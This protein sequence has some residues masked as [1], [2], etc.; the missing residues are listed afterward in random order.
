MSQS[1][2]PVVFPNKN[3]L[4][5]FGML[6]VPSPAPESQKPAILLLSPGI[7]SRIG[8]HRLY[9]KMAAR[10]IEMGFTVLRF[11]FYGLG[12]S[13]GELTESVM[14]NFY[15]SIEKGRYVE[16]TLMAMDWMERELGI[17][18]FILSGLCG[19]A[20]TGLIAA[21]RDPRVDSLI[22]LGIP[23]TLAST[24]TESYDNV[25][26]GQ[27]NRLR[28]KYIRKIIDPKAWVRLL[29]L[30]TDFRLL[31]KAL[32]RPIDNILRSGKPNGDEDQTFSGK[33]P[34]GEVRSGGGNF[35]RLFPMAFFSMVSTN[36]R[37]LLIFSEKDRL[38]WEFDEKFHRP[39]RSRI[40]TYRNFVQLHVTK[41]ANHIFSSPESQEEMM[42]KAC[43][44]LEVHYCA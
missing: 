1:V 43:S 40:E 8:P 11:D 36:R 31:F 9:V 17:R 2:R 33:D 15:G 28:G 13:E 22:G 32:S 34:E 23:V 39:Y 27:L 24:E 10:F 37:L 20:I 12:D 44:W 3:G 14:A 21:S 16:D 26:E 4:H 25:S 30:K 38:Y 6:H 29:T 42:G 7:K 19:G 41:D 5:L 18:R 35:N